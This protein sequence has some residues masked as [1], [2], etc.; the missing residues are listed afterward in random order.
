MTS[1][2][3]PLVERVGRLRGESFHHPSY[4]ISF[5]A[6]T[7]L[8]FLGLRGY[9][10]FD[11][12]WLFAPGQ[13]NIVEP[14]ETLGID[15]GTKELLA[16]AIELGFH[17]SSARQAMHWAVSRIALHTGVFDVTANTD[18]HIAEALEAIRFFAEH[19]DLERFYPS[20]Q[21]YRDGAAKNWITHLHQLQVVLYHRGQVSTQPRQLMPSWK[22]PLVLPPR[23][24]TVAERWLAA[25]RL[26]DR[27]ATVVK[28]E[29]AVR[30][31]GDRLGE[32]HPEIISFADVTRDHCLG[33]MQHLTEA[34]TERT[35]R[36]LGAVSR[37]QRIS[38]LTQFFRDTA[39]WEYDDVPGRALITHRDAPRPPA[40]T[41]RFIPE[42]ELNKL[43]PVIEEITCPYQ[44]AAL[45][46]ARWSGARRDEIRRAPLDRLDSYPDSTPRLRL[47]AGKTYTERV[48]P[49]HEDAAK[50]LREVIAL[51]RDGRERPFIDELTSQPVQY[52][53]IKHGKP[54][55]THYL[56]ETS[57]QQACKATGLIG[58]GGGEGAGR[59]TIT[60]HRLRHT[61]GTRLAERGARLHTIMKVLGHSSVSMALVYAQ[62]SDREVL[63]DYQA[64]LEPGATIAGPAAAD[65]KSG[66]LPDEAVNRLESNFFKTELELGHCLRLPA[67]G[68]G[69]PRGSRTTTR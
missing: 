36:P 1:S 46:V 64:V 31:F 9:A 44:R 7:Y 35:G 42:D 38:G 43:M 62:I 32:H 26:T 67:E 18:D 15:L 24:Q 13:I 68:P 2:A 3:V 6:R 51:R 8:V 30:R 53:F 25:R 48:V 16:E 58:P 20:A 41:P 39:A 56:F 22:P 11:Y 69:V 17:P 59:G 61:V 12:P 27:P 5:R 29:L 63:R 54:L 49:L 50:A 28:L 19:L 52:L 34:P 37:I 60:A 4:P 40:R 14:A 66:V 33:W 65:L 45:L 10:T 55:S 21:R 23:M 47:P 57:I